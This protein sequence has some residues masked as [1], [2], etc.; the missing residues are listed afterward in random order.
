MRFEPQPGEL[1]A[2][3]ACFHRA[4]CVDREEPRMQSTTPVTPRRPERCR[5]RTLTKRP[6]RPSQ[7]HGGPAK[8]EG[9]DRSG[10]SWF[11]QHGGGV[12]QAEPSAQCLKT[13]QNATEEHERHSA[14]GDSHVALHIDRIE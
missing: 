5:D 9:P 3:A 8:S 2:H 10:P 12:L 4:R 13:N 14:V 1:A 6:G 7:G 11:H